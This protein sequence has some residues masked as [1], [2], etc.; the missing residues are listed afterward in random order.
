MQI[1]LKHND[2]QAVLD[3]AVRYFQQATTRCGTMFHGEFKCVYVK[4]DGTRC[5]AGDQ[6]DADDDILR[7]MFLE[8]GI[9]GLGPGVGAA[10]E[11]QLI[12]DDRGNP[13]FR[14]DPI[15]ELLVELQEI[16]DDRLSWGSDGFTWWDR[17]AWTADL[18]D[19]AYSGPGDAAAYDLYRE[20]HP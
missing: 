20:E 15:I 6:F 9:G 10:T 16:H 13:Y 4:Y 5:V 11:D 2:L 12:V 14:D 17:L 7:A 1:K 18:F 19:L 8:S 3:D